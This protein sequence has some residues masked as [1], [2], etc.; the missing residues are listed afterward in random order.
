MAYLVDTCVLIDYL[1]DRLPARSGDWFEG[2]I[3]GGWICTSVVVYHE[4]WTGATTLKAQQSVKE[5]LAEWDI[6][7]VDLAI[8]CQAAEI[9][10]MWR[11][12]GMTL[13]MA[14]ALIGATAQLY[15]LKL[16]TRNIKD[17]PEVPTVDPFHLE[18][19][20]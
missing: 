11:G 8:A 1:L 7:P 12:K 15:G 2:L 5:L 16:I 6:I 3:G 10:R 19:I 9:R 4:L 20:L 14:D 17:F 13:S 18:T